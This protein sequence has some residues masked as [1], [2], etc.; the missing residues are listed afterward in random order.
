MNDRYP[1]AAIEGK[2]QKYWEEQGLF[3]SHNADSDKKYYCLTMFPYPS[4]TM[5]VGH[6]RNYIIGDVVTRYKTAHGYSVLSP[7]GWDS[8]GLP[9]ENY[10][11]KTGTHPNII[12]QKNKAAIGTGK[13]RESGEPNYCE[14]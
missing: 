12:T 14:Y 2:W 9:K 13:N 3:Q 8:F 5:H 6:G 7:M 4:G 1:P 10:A 11:I